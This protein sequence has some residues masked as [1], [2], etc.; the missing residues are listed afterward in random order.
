MRDLSLYE[1]YDKHRVE[2][3]K[4][5]TPQRGVALMVTPGLSS[6]WL[7]ILKVPTRAPE[8]SSS[9]IPKHG[10]LFLKAGLPLLQT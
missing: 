10:V 1:F 7:Q 3:G 5:Q 2:R 6:F 8:N 9:K 4:L